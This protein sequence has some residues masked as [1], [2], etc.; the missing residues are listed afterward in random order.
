MSD[1]PGDLLQRKEIRK[2]QVYPGHGRELTVLVDVELFDDAPHRLPL[3]LGVF[4]GHGPLGHLGGA[5][6][7]SWSQH[8]Q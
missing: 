4:S 2:E 5:S 8:W 6:R 3:G 7:G 1:P